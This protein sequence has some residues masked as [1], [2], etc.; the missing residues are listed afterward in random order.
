MVA[1][2]DSGIELEHIVIFA[3][4]STIFAAGRDQDNHIRIFLINERSGNVYSRNGR[5]ESWE[6]VY[7]D[8]RAAVIEDISRA[9]Y[10]R[11]IPIYRINGTCNA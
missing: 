3:K 10:N 9:R 8:S 1:Y 2:R 5:V 7:G 4:D 11:S 6:E